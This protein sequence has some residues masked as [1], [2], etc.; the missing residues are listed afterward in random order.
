M[1][2]RSTPDD[3]KRSRRGKDPEKEAQHK[4]MTMTARL[5]APTVFSMNQPI[6]HSIPR[7][8]QAPLADAHSCTPADARLVL[9]L[10][11][12]SSQQCRQPR[13]VPVSPRPSPGRPTDAL[14]APAELRAQQRLRTPR[15]PLRE[16][17]PHRLHPRP[18]VSH[19]EAGGSV[20]PHRRHW[21]L[22]PV[23]DLRL[24]TCDSPRI[25]QH[26]RELLFHLSLFQ[27]G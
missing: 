2:F 5:A 15:L 14:P 9:A 3:D 20:R 27:I 18:R 24:P 8:A 6:V 4:H 21:E 23:R 19:Q 1:L 10:A 11:A 26:L 16:P 22:D 13:S 25:R 17:R 12:V 7:R